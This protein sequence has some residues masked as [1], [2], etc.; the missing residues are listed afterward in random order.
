MMRYDMLFGTLSAKGLLR[1]CRSGEK[2][3]ADNA[4]KESMQMM[5]T[6]SSVVLRFLEVL[7]LGWHQAVRQTSR[8]QRGSTLITEAG[9]TPLADVRK[10]RTLEER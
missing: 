3:S 4:T 10:A 2:R 8:H 1:A 9:A 6:C 5:G 7:L